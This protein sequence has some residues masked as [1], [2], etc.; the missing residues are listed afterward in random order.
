MCGRGLDKDVNK[1]HLDH[2]HALE[3]PNAGKVRGLLC[4]LCNV[5]EGTMKHKFYRSG[6]ASRNVDYITWLKSLVKYL[7]T[8]YSGNDIHPQFIPDTIKVFKRL[9]LPEMQN[10]MVLRGYTFELSDTKAILV[11]KFSKQFRQE[12]KEL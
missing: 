4:G 11:K 9:S 7:E 5:L 3:G 6:L 8:D 10:E 1:N 2:D 12:Q